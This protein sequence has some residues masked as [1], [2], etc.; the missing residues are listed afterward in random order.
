MKVNGI[1]CDRILEEHKDRSDD[2]SRGHL[3]RLLSAPSQKTVIL[4]L[5]IAETRSY[6]RV[7]NSDDADQNGDRVT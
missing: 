4:I 5:T 6:T 3:R 7:Y 1:L 2:E